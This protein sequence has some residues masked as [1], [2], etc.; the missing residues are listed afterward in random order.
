MS[1]FLA[2]GGGISAPT[3][4]RRLQAPG[5]G[6]RAIYI[7]WACGLFRWLYLL[8]DGG[9][10][11]RG[12]GCGGLSPRPQVLVLS[13]QYSASSPQTTGL[14]LRPQP[15]VLS[16]YSSQIHIRPSLSLLSFQLFYKRSFYTSQK[17]FI[18]FISRDMNVILRNVHH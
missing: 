11:R 2:G 16:N 7:L 3:V 5:T 18:L 10:R 13:P 17:N 14:A 9:Y 4:C 6:Y 15:L 8:P 1:L 12:L